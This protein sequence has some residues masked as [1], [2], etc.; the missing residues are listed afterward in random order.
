MPRY[1]YKCKQCDHREE[2]EH[3][4]KLTPEFICPTC[5]GEVLSRVIG[6]PGFAMKH[7]KE[8]RR[9]RDKHVREQE[10][11]QDLQENHMVEKIAPV[12]GSSITQVYNE[13]KASGGA[14]KEQM[15]KTI[16]KNEAAKRIKQKEWQIGANK[17]VEK[18]TMFAREKRA[19]EAAAKRKISIT[20]KK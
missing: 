12:G 2:H 6:C 20:T 8:A 9:L 5:E 10:M 3:S 13:V 18:R 4:F 19:E 7:S 16:E 15:Q 17:R 11:R 14:T 1:D